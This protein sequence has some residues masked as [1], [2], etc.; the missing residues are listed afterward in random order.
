MTIEET[1][2]A[3]APSLT[4]RL[5]GRLV[6]SM[7]KLPGDTV[8]YSIRR[9]LPVPMKDG[10]TLLGNLYQPSEMSGPMPV[11]LVRSPYGR[12]GVI[13][14]GEVETLARRGFQVFVQSCRGTFGSGGQF[15]A[16]TTER[17]DGLATLEWVRAQSWCDGRVATKGASYLG[18]TQWAIAPF[19]DPPLVASSITVAASRII[20]GFYDRG[21]PQLEVAL[22]WVRLV[23][24]KDSG[25]RP[26][27]ASLLPDPAR[28]RKFEQVARSLPLQ[29]A[30][31][32]LT[33]EEVPFWREFVGHAE[34]DDD[35]WDV[36]DFS[37][38]DLA[39]MPP[40]NMVTGWY[41]LFMRGQLADYTRL[42]EAGVEARLTIGPWGHGRPDLSGA[43]V[44]SDLIWLGHYLLDGPAPE[45]P[46][47]RFF[48]QEADEWIETDFWPPRGIGSTALYLHGDA[49]LSDQPVD[50]PADAVTSFTYDPAD[51]TPSAGGAMLSVTSPMRVDNRH[52]ESRS[53]VAVFT[54]PSLAEYLDVIGT[55]VAEIRVR[56][57]RPHA[58]LF[59]RLCDVSPDGRSMNVT[60]GIRRLSPK[61]VPAED[62]EVDGDGTLLVTLELMPTAY[63][64]RKG[65]RLRL[66]VSGGAFPRYARNLGNGQP[67]ASATSWE[68]CTIE[69]LHGGSNSSCLR[70]PVQADRNA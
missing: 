49:S 35:H 64:F 38:V 15:R 12:E 48:L 14:M 9:D 59:V 70:L 62:V 66:Q 67:M 31:V 36:G 2:R 21:A 34:P 5:L 53:D 42:R 47:V 6:D 51:P 63:R 61:S 30:D 39:G 58:D 16:F 1:S 28:A 50:H 20:T 55:V 7:L 22:E 69:L 17:E 23:S 33:G 4:K 43:A 24:K 25:F 65:H 26:L 32:A 3:I 10:A 18:H 60:D 29:A 52:I 68:T 46:P 56:T 19:A 27:I 41:D 57:S 13:P 37:N 54:G 40:T 45:G 44:R 11:V 8:P